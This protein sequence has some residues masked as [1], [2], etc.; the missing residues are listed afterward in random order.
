MVSQYKYRWLQLVTSFGKQY[1]LPLLVG[2]LISIAVIGLRE[3]FVIE[4]Q[5]KIE[6][7]I[8]QQAIAIQTE[9]ATE[10]KTRIIALE[11]MGGRWQVRGG[12]PQK[13]WEADAASSVKDFG[14]YRAIEWVDPSL[15]VRWIVP[16][17]RNEKAL[18]FDLSQETR[19][20]EA[21]EKARDRHRTTL[22]RTVNLVVGGKGFLAYIPL[23][24]EDKFDGFIL[25]VFQIQPFFDSVVHVPRVYKIKVFEGQELIYGDDSQLTKQSPWQQEINVNLYGL[26]WRVQIYPTPELLTNLHSR[27]PTVVLFVGL[28]FATTLTLL[29]YFAQATKASNYQIAAINQELSLRVLEQKKVEVALRRQALTFE[30]IHDA[31]IVTD[32][33]GNITDWSPSAE[34]IFGYTKAEVLGKTPPDILQHAEET[35]TSLNNMVLE[36]IK[37][38]RRWS[39]EI[40]VV[41]KDGSQ[42]ICRSTVVPL[43][44]EHEQTIAIIG[45]LQDITERK[46]TE[47]LLIESEERFQS[48]MNYSPIPAWITDTDGMFL[49]VSEPYLRVFQLPTREMI[50][51]TVSD[52]YPPEFAQQFI[53]NIQRVAHTNQVLEAVES[54]PCIDGI[55]RDFLV[56][57]FPIS[58]QIDRCLVG[59]IAI[60]ITERQQAERAIQKQL[61]RTMLLE[62]ITQ[63][64]RQSLDTKKI[65]ATAA[66]QIGQAFK[67]DRCLI[68]SYVSDATPQIPIVAEYVVPGCSSM[69]EL[70]MPMVGNPDV[71]KIILQDRAIASPNVYLDALLQT[72]EPILRQIDLKS[73]LVIRTSY[74]GKPNGIIGIHQCSHFR[75]WTPEEIELLEAV[76]A[77]LGIALA[78]AD[79][80]EQESQ[81]LEELTWNNWALKQAKREAEA[82]NRAKSEFLAMMSHEIRTPM[83]AVIGMTGL[84]LD[85]ELTPEQHNFVEIIRSSSDALLTIINDILDFSKI[86][87]G[88]LDLEEHP[89]NLRYCI[90][91]ALDLLAA[92]AAAKNLDLAYLIDCQ[93]PKTI[94]GDVTRVRQ[95]LVNLIGN[96]VKFTKVGEVVVSVTVKQVISQDKYEIQFAIK[97]TGIGIPEER[98]ERLFKPFSQVDASMNRQY[99]GT[100]LGLVITKRLCEMMG[101]SIWVES[102]VGVGST[103]YFTLVAES[104]SSPEI[105]DLE[106][107]QPN[108]TGKRLLVVDDN[109]TNRQVIGVQASNWGMIVRS[110][111]SGLQALA[112]INSGEEFDIAVLDM[113]MPNMDGLILA[114]II[115]S[116]PKC[117]ELPLVMLSSV[118]KLPNK[119]QGAKSDFAAT[120]NK[121]IKRSHLYNVFIRILYGERISLLPTQSLPLV[122]NSQLSQQLPLR[123]LLVEDISLNQKVALQILKR[124]GYR[125][126][127]AS[128]GLEALS[129][130]RQQ[131]YDLVF[132]DVQMP[133]MDGLQATRRI[134]Q[135][136]PHH[137]RPWIIA[138][139]AHAMQGD[140]EECLSA[141]MNDYI[142]KPIRA[143]ALIQVFNNYR[144]FQRSNTQIKDFINR[145]EQISQ[146]EIN[147]EV[148]LASA[149]DSE[150]FA[151]LTD[152]T[153]DDAGEILAEFIDGYLEDAPQ[154]L[155]AI[156][157]AITRED[158][159]ALRSAA[160][161]LRS[162]SATVGAMPLAQL[163]EELEAI[164]RTD[165]IVSASTLV[166]QIE[167][168]YQRVKT[169]LQLQH[170]Q[171][172]ND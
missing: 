22:T 162:L 164:A 30:N 145:N 31:A 151:A 25:G 5:S 87:S 168:E 15:R 12:T 172:K 160:H 57:K 74:Q 37:Q 157:N 7:L 21:L 51:K 4:E 136:W 112:L 39:D 133:E 94:V 119:Q 68:H 152:I 9:L 99:G 61:Q 85:M 109:A 49:Y 115:H 56:Y 116:L 55:V 98:L 107:V 134:C 18:N 101:G 135:E 106:V 139:T 29:T 14:G 60:D 44:D 97:D 58:S 114:R 156:G 48:F 70:E 166:S 100:G 75:Q 54:A 32:L 91:E 123:I 82:A 59:G 79:L 8:Y 66:I 150:I 120:L 141:G 83:N 148:I 50:G 102:S 125:A 80:L 129:A 71:E 77:Q 40:N 84:L 144:I 69:L 17:A 2:I 108:L 159:A 36:G 6:Q 165:N 64:I 10:L 154:R 11:R 121:P 143:E 138:M 23:F 1:V 137:K 27:I 20:R 103:F 117:Q 149:I 142:S 3:W 46:R 63:E 169:A 111:E 42:G 96:A 158:A 47:V 171:N 118:E 113:Q 163:C 88:K 126:D 132:M 43:R 76:A 122:F 35:A 90:E 146:I 16:L 131:F 24:L 170:P 67:V 45:F 130:L 110:V 72:A 62:Q 104:A 95:I 73:L 86:E 105:V 38:Q 127:V 28:L 128:N 140:R 13:E 52:I 78:H 65:F 33:A 153:G 89:F 147:S 81:R 26:N 19:R 161:A 53:D 124:L 167:T 34:R 41:R 93:N 155:L 92:E